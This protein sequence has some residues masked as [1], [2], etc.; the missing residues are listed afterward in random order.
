MIVL[1]YIFIKLQR[2][3]LKM[4]RTLIQIYLLAS[5]PIAFLFL[6]IAHVDFDRR[7]FKYYSVPVY[8][9]AVIACGGII[10]FGLDP[11]LTFIPDTW[12][13]VDEDNEVQTCR[14][15]IRVMYWVSLIVGLVWG[16]YKLYDSK[17]K[18]R[19]SR[20]GLPNLLDP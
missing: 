13:Y 3:I 2:I 20:D 6:A 4:V 15:D 8:I 12:T 1:H 5:L 9:G 19:K 10:L 14:D 18:L 17:R 11:L 16:Y 7:Y